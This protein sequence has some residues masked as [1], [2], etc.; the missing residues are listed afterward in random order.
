ISSNDGCRRHAPRCDEKQGKRSDFASLNARRPGDLQAE[1]GECPG[2]FFR[3]TSPMDHRP[4]RNTGT[5]VSEICFGTRR[6]AKRSRDL[7]ETD[8]ETA[9]DLLDTAWEGETTNTF[10][11]ERHDRITDTHEER[12]Q[13]D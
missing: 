10:S 9:H 7:V 1:Q 5:K 8:P 6:F 12:G 4:I 13:W 3:G 2:A 11:S